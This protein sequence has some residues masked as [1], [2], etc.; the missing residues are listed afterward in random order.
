V[1]ILGRTAAASPRCQT[2]SENVMRWRGEIRRCVLWGASVG[3]FSNCGAHWESFRRLLSSHKRFDSARRGTVGIF[4][5]SRIFPH[6][7]PHAEHVARAKPLCTFDDRPFGRPAWYMCP[8]TRPSAHDRRALV[9]QPR[10]LL[11][12]EL[13]NALDIAHNFS[14]ANHERTGPVRMAILLVTHQ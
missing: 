6:Q 4:Q 5:Q 8:P 14:C 13:R 12:D 2:F 11:F 10:T 7:H 9:H 3:K 1:C